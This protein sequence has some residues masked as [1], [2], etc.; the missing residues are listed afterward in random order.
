MLKDKYAVIT[1]GSDGIGLAIAKE[2]AS[3][4]AKLCLVARDEDKLLAAQQE[5]EGKGASVAIVKGDL[6]IMTEVKRIADELL[7]IAPDID[8]L[9]NNAGVGYFIPFEQTDEEAFDR[10]FNLNVKA[11]YFLTQHLLPSLIRRK[12]NIIHISSY[13]SHRMLPGRASTVYSATKGAIDS[14][15][16]SLAFE[17]GKNGV[18]VNAIA[19]GSIDTPQLRRNV[20]LLSEEEKVRFGN[21]IQTIY[22]LGRIGEGEDVGRM[23]AFL[24][25]DQAKWITGAIMAVDGGLTTN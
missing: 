5:L 4:G 17:V 19:P 15:T 2:F 16:K 6:G 24:A 25:S 18:R 12:G 3:Q 7:A 23:A 8:I 1:G 20:S 9:V 11:P 22:P 13:F 14:F 21:I 10:H